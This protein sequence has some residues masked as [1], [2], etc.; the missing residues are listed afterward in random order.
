MRARHV[1]IY[2]LLRVRGHIIYKNILFQLYRY[3][4]FTLFTVVRTSWLLTAFDVCEFANIGIFAPFTFALE[5]FVNKIT[6]TSETLKIA[7]FRSFVVY[8][9]TFVPK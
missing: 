3:L 2:V 8:K 5:N 1:R 6:S 7:P 9:S 4:L